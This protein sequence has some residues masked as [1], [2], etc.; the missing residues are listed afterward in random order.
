MVSILAQTR[1]TKQ[2]KVRQL[3]EDNTHPNSI[4]ALCAV[5]VEEVQDQYKQLK[6]K[7][8]VPLRL[9][10]INMRKPVLAAILSAWVPI[11]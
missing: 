8:M 6:W 4:L 10:P 11:R 5:T 9:P 2:D 1:G 3:V 7:W